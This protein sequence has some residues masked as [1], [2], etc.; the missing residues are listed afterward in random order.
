MTF[1]NGDGTTANQRF[2]PFAD[3]MTAESAIYVALED[4]GDFLPNC[5]HVEIIRAGGTIRSEA[6]L[7]HFRRQPSP[8]DGD[9]FLK[10]G[11]VMIIRP[12]VNYF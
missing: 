11:D 9:F 2:I 7:R 1:R 10:R 5:Y 3:R 12:K 8:S 4:Q 6:D